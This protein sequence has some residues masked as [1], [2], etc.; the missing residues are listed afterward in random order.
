ME[1]MID[2]GRQ[3]VETGMWALYEVENDKMTFTGP[4]KGI[5]DGARERKPVLEYLQGQGR[6]SHLFKP[7]PNENALKEIDSYLAKVW[8]RYRKQAE[9]LK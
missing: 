3:A 4:S 6:F 9:C 7:A 1:N 8:D 2:L 5:L